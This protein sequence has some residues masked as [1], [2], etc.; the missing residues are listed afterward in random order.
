MKLRY[1]TPSSRTIRLTPSL[2]LALSNG[3]QIKVDS[4][5]AG[6]GNFS[7]QRKDDGN[8][9]EAAECSQPIRSPIAVSS[10]LPGR[11]CGLAAHLIVRPA[12]A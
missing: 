10:V 3:S 5:K 9:E 11:L 7:N 6:P 12:W 2:P 4:G 8:E 1:I